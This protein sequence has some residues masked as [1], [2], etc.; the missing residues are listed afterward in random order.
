[1]HFFVPVVYKKMPRICKYIQSFTQVCS[2]QSSIESGYIY[3]HNNV[4]LGDVRCWWNEHLL[5]H[6]VIT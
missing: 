3:Q 2:V 1:M 4:E 5:L 6:S